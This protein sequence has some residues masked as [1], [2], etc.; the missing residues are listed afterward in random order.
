MLANFEDKQV[1]KH[2]PTTKKHIVLRE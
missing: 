1:M 2:I